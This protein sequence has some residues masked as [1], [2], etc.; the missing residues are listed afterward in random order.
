MSDP[1]PSLTAKKTIGLT[2]LTSNAMALIAPGAFL[3]LTYCQQSMY[4]S[5]SV[6]SAMWLGIV[7]ATL[8]CLATAVAYAELSKLYPGAGSSYFFAEQAF[9]SKTKA[10]K[11]ARVAKFMV[12][13]A[14]H[15]YYWVYPGLMAGVTAAMGTPDYMAPEQVLGKRGDPRTDIY[16]LGAMLYEMVT[17]RVPF[18]GENPFYVMQARVTGDPPAPRRFNSDLTE[19]VEEIILHAMEREPKDRYASAEDFERELKRPD[20]VILTGRAARLQTPKLWR[21]R[22]R[23]IFRAM[24]LLLI[25]VVVIAVI[26]LTAGRHKGNAPHVPTAPVGGHSGA[27]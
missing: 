7:F 17:G 18:A 19:E 3:W 21:T 6:G 2:G 11:F 10:Y 20:G 5:P 1:S 26:W 12:G 23:R 9:L 16:S 22:L 4:G 13:W 15:L 8:L 25:P 24:G 14:S 27:K